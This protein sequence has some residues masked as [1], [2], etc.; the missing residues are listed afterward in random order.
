MDSLAGQVA[1]VTGAGKGIGREIARTFAG[2]GARL[3]LVARTKSDLESAR[4][5][6][7]ECGSEARSIAGDVRDEATA[8]LAVNEALDAF[9]R[10]DILVNNAGIAIHHPIT[11]VGIAEFDAVMDTN[12]RGTFL[13]AHAT[14]PVFMR[15]KRG[16][17]IVIGSGAGTRG[18][19]T[20]SVYCASKFAQ[21]GFALALDQELRQHSIKV[22]LIL[23]GNVATAMTEKNFPDQQEDEQ[24]R[25][26]TAQDVAR[27]ALF[28]A[29][30]PIQ[31]HV[32][33]L[34]LRPTGE[35][36]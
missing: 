24:M 35:M 16:T 28:I 25:L 19:A 34:V 33:E 30:Q 32:V 3:V 8:A 17:V 4:D 11:D 7:D 5:E 9:G 12:M 26:L 18:I 22:S 1:I 29:T 36:I 20:E 23:P 14:I 2:E 13:F 10:L 21:R 6:V 15:Q 27:A 31:S